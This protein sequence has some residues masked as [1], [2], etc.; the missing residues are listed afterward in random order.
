MKEENNYMVYL[1]L[2]THKL[3]EAHLKGDQKTIDEINNKRAKEHKEW[4]KRESQRLKELLTPIEL[5]VFNKID[6]MYERSSSGTYDAVH[7]GSNYNYRWYIDLPIHEDYDE[8][9][10]WGLSFHKGKY[11]LALTN[12][13]GWMTEDVWIQEDISPEVVFT[14]IDSQK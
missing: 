2:E 12:H 6:S 8:D 10:S 11:T 3:L 4:K 7:S 13:W 9:T 14:I 1:S 5:E